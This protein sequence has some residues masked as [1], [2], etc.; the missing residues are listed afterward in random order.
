MRVNVQLADELALLGFTPLELAL[1]GPRPAPTGTHRLDGLIPES[2]S[3][4]ALQ[5]WHFATQLDDPIDSIVE[6]SAADRSSVGD[7]LAAHEACRR[8]IK[9]AR[10]VRGGRDKE[11]V[12]AIGFGS[13]HCWFAGSTDG[14][15]FLYRFEP[16]NT[17]MIARA[18]REI[19]DARIEVQTGGN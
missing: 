16:S 8:L 18:A 7:A 3:E 11:V 12:S 4:R 1:S 14:L 6:V 2:L 13:E 19:S 17:G 10:Q 5:R 9:A 15:M